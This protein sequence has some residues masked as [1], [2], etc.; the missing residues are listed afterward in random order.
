MGEEGIK[1]QQGVNLNKVHYMHVW[2]YHNEI[3]LYN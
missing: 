3:H 2:K 1:A